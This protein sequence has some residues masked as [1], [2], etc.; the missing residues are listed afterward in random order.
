M[1]LR[2]LGS[3]SKWDQK[4]INLQR[5]D[6]GVSGDAIS[7]LRTQNNTLSVWKIDN[8]ID[9][10][11]AIV[12]LALNRDDS[13]KL[14]YCLLDETDILN[15]GITSETYP[16]QAPGLVDENILAKHFNL[17]SLDFWR[18]GFLAEYIL[19]TIRNPSNIKILTKKEILDLLTK[20]KNKNIIS[21]DSMKES[22]RNNLRW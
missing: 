11:D 21:V 8:Q 22:L 3:I 18:L 12:A 1:F 4:T 10:E 2:M 16:G 7:D 5:S 9:I 17:V 15:M 19:L 20:Y 6:A 13:S 14:C